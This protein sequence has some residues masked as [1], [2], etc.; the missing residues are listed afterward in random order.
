[1][2]AESARERLLR[3]LADSPDPAFTQS[4]ALLRGWVQG[5]PAPVTRYS[6]PLPGCGWEHD[7][8][9]ADGPAG[10]ETVLRLH[11]DDHSALEYVRA[12]LAAQD[13][14]RAVRALHRP[15]TLMGQVWCDECSTQRSTGPHAAERIAYIPHPCPT[16]QALDGEAV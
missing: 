14:E 9:P 4:D 7:V 1:V 13:R 5:L 8:T 12:L 16:I 15:V 6:C 3:L 11:V 10:V 2:T